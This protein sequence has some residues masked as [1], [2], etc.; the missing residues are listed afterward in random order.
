[1]ATSL[2]SAPFPVGRDTCPAVPALLL[3]RGY[4][5]RPLVQD[6]L[7]WL[8]D[9]YASTRAEELAEVPWPEA[10]KRMFLDGQFALQHQ[11]YLAHFSDANFLAIER[12]GGA[13][14]RYYLQR[15]PSHDLIVDISLFPAERGS[16]VASALIA[17][18]QHEACLRGSGMELHVH[19]GNSAALRLYQRLGF[20]V[21][22]HQGPHLLMRW[23]GPRA[24]D[25][26]SVS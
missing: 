15:N 1:M 11:H 25:A 21:G 19:I 20:V 10:A 4:T 7:P 24:T 6:D 8:R 12:G 23:A 9:L 17:H 5:L 22:A 16:G 13:V 14:G 18:S 26:A 3:Q 2:Q